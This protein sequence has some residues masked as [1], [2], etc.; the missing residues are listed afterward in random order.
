M[1]K[2]VI[3]AGAA[4]VLVAN[5]AAAG[6]FA[7]GELNHHPLAAKTHWIRKGWVGYPGPPYGIQYSRAYSYAFSSGYYQSGYAGCVGVQH[8]C[9]SRWGWS[10]SGFRRCLSNHRW[11]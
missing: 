3:A 6:P 4:C 7:T 10:G 9:A 8:M 2:L 1:K 11:C 5:T